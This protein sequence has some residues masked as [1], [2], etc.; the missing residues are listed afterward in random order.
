MGDSPNKAET[1]RVTMSVG[2]GGSFRLLREHWGIAE[3]KRWCCKDKDSAL[4]T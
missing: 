1:G 3:L 2:G 4:N